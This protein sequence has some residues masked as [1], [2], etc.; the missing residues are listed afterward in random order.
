MLRYQLEQR[1][2]DLEILPGLRTRARDLRRL[3]SRARPW[4]RARAAA[5][6]SPCATRSTIPTV[7]HLHGGHTPAE[8]D[9]YPTD[10]LLPVG[11]TAA[12][13]L[14]GMPADPAARVASGS[15]VHAYP[16]QQR[17]A[18]LWY[19]DHTMA[20]TA[21][22]VWRG[23]FGMHLVHDDE[24]DALGLPSGDRDLPVAICDRSFAA[25]GSLLYPPVTL[26]HAAWPWSRRSS[27]T[28][29]S[30]T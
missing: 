22:N 9:G 29:F 11:V 27:R 6:R 24:E 19:H 20:A 15:R 26:E 13:V 25:D 2:A 18:T 8:S 3:P 7:T 1:T 17:A 30:A 28:A 5:P 12:P 10:L 23:L 21:Q 14:P 4:S 16:M